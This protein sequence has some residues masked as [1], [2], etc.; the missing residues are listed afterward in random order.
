MA[1]EDEEVLVRHPAGRSCRTRFLQ[2]A[3]IPVA[4]LVVVRGWRR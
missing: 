4:V 2:L 3:V 1:R